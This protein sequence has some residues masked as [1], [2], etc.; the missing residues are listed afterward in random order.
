[1]IKG[2]LDGVKVIDLSR[3]IAGPHCS[4]IL[5]DFGADII[6]VEVKG[7]GD[8]G[9]GFAPFYQGESTYFLTHNRN[10]RSITLNYRHPKANGILLSL[11]KDADVLVENYKAGTLE[12]MG[13]DPKMLLELNPRLIIT[14][15]SGFGQDGPYASRPCY[16]AV[17]QSISGLMDVTGPAD[18]PPVMLGLYICD[19]TSGLYG[20]IGT[21]AALQ[22][23]TLTG[24][25]Q[26]VDVALLD[27][28]CALTHSSIINYYQLGEVM[29]RIGNQDRAS[30]PA[31]FYNSKDG[32]LLYI[33]ASQDSAFAKFCSMI[34]REDLLEDERFCTFNNR[35]ANADACDE[36]V[37]SWTITKTV[38]EILELCEKYGIPC[39]RVN[40]MGEMA[41]DPQLIYR[42]M[43]REVQHPKLG[44]LIMNGPTVKMSDTNPDVFLPP[45]LLGQHNKEIYGGMLGYSDEEIA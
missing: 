1:M 33:Q 39:A 40:N 11:L 29:Q 34:G 5:G 9:R 27:A 25:G 32:R 45:P 36:L 22:A 20:A 24:K 28:A 13:L 43:V 35:F 4:M 17:A 38:A 2:A 37:G 10:K 26:V 6:K 12:A 41:Q 18:G 44:K 3:V 31:N 15:M 19:F 42:K 14:R 8:M 30:S 23:R 7:T 21:L 16:D